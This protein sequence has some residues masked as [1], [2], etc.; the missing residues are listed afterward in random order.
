MSARGTSL[1]EAR[2]IPRSAGCELSV[3]RAAGERTTPPG[4]GARRGELGRGGRPRA[5]LTGLGARC[6]RS[7][8]RDAR[9][10][11][12]HMCGRRGAGSHRGA[13]ARRPGRTTIARPGVIAA[14]WS[15][16]VRRASRGR[17]RDGRSLSGRGD[18]VC[19]HVH[20]R[21][22]RRAVAGRRSMQRAQRP[23][24]EQQELQE[25]GAKQRG[26]ES[27]A[28]RHWN[29]CEGRPVQCTD[30]TVRGRSSRGG[31]SAVRSSVEVASGKTRRG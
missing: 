30:P 24:S 18:V 12:C 29:R 3:S 25:Q 6:R 7:R 8:R 9:R 1:A 10:H 28:E 13:R 21:H 27:F 14:A 16:V 15:Q 5:H 2:A 31:S 4:S 22:R 19:G 26:T 17:G 11:R 23:A 20:P